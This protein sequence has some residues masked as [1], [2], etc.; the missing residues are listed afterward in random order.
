[1][2][3]NRIVHAVRT[4]RDALFGN[5]A[6]DLFTFA[7]FLEA[8][9][10]RILGG[11]QTGPYAYADV[12]LHDKKSTAVEI[13]CSNI[14]YDTTDANPRAY[15]K[16]VNLRGRANAKDTHADFVVLVGYIGASQP[17]VLEIVMPEEH[18]WALW[19]WIVPYH[20][21]VAKVSNSGGLEYKISERVGKG[22]YKPSWVT[23]HWIGWNEP[24]LLGYFKRH[25]AA[26]RANT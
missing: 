7:D 25:S 12:I 10:A 11:S 2:A 13:K 8:Y 16:W 1:M 4:Q 6:L 26:L 3:T 15:F 19:F 24:S 23:A 18:R 21:L 14:V 20:E 17:E 22:L 9:L 5:T